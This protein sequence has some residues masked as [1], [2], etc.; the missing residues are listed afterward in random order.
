MYAVYLLERSFTANATLAICG[1]PYVDCVNLF[2]VHSW[3]ISWLH[4]VWHIFA[5]FVSYLLTFIRVGLTYVHLKFNCVHVILLPFS[6]LACV[7]VGLF[8]FVSIKIMIWDLLRSKFPKIFKPRV[9]HLVCHMFA[10]FICN[11]IYKGLLLLQAHN[12]ILSALSV[13][14]LLYFFL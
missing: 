4:L 6:I 14:L 8:I 12:C 9:V 2:L 13:P 10:T 5:T 11:F 3:T 1:A 7:K